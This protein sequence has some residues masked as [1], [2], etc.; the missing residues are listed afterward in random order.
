MTAPTMD[1]AM[2]TGL[3][4]A[5]VGALWAAG[6]VLSAVLQGSNDWYPDLLSVVTRLGFAGLFWEVLDLRKQLHT[7][8]SGQHKRPRR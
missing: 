3:W 7:A 5:I 1:L 2:R 4:I 8:R 6:G